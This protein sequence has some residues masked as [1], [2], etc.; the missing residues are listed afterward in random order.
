MFGN[1][2]GTHRNFLIK[3]R[4]P[5]VITLIEKILQENLKL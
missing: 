4:V 1:V 5:I 2:S 3:S